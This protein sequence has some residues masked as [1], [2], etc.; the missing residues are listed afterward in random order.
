MSTFPFI[1]I[2]TGIG[3]KVVE[4]LKFPYAVTA[5][6]CHKIKNKLI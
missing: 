5:M 1:N 6:K 3:S 2:P 4:I